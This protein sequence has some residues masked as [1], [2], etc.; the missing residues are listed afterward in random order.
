MTRTS[1]GAGLAEHSAVPTKIAALLASMAE[2]LSVHTGSLDATDENALIERG[3]YRKLIDAHRRAAEMLSA[4]GAEMARCRD[5]PPATHDLEA[6]A[7]AK[8]RAV[9]EDVVKREREL[10]ALLERRVENDEKMLLD[11]AAHRPPFSDV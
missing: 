6:V 4:T 1:C 3:A 2:M 10:L 5:L 9:F 8:A 7:S 11:M